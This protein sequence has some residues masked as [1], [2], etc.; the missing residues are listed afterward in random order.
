MNNRKILVI[1]SLI[2]ATVSAAIIFDHRRVNLEYIGSLR[3]SPSISNDEFAG[4]VWEACRGSAMQDCLY[5]TEEWLFA[6][7]KKRFTIVP[8]KNQFQADTIYYYGI[9][10][11]IDTI[12]YFYHSRY[13]NAVQDSRVFE[14]SAFAGT[15]LPDRN[16]IIIYKG[17]VFVSGL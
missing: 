17:D 9:G 14:A 8:E 12:N 2:V 11:S 3:I 4:C 6:M 13:F 10:C 1:F 7:S 5:S 16:L 15:A